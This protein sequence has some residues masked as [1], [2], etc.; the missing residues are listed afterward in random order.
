MTFVSAI[1]WCYGKFLK[2]YFG[3]YNSEKLT[4]KL[5]GKYSK[6]KKKKA[7]VRLIMF[8]LVFEHVGIFLPW[9]SPKL[10][11]RHQKHSLMSW[12]YQEC[13]QL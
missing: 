11:W 6:N 12:L 1:W 9:K 5:K 4:N 7:L 3:F 8:C 13:Q 2:H 10:A